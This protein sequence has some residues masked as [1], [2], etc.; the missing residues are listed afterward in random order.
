MNQE[1]KGKLMCIKNARKRSGRNAKQKLETEDV[2][3]YKIIRYFIILLKEMI[4]LMKF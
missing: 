1:K 2:L 4:K 3:V